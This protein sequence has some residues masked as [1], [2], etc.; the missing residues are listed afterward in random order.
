MRKARQTID[1]LAEERLP[2]SINGAIHGMELSI[3]T[4]KSSLHVVM[5]RT[6]FE[7]QAVLDWG[8]IAALVVS[9]IQI[10][11]GGKFWP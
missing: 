5:H 7:I 10:W 4:H 6:K 9:L 8:K 2:E 3:F 11:K 1:E